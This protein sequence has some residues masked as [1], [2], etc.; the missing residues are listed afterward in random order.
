MRKGTSRV[1]DTR[2]AGQCV[3][4]GELSDES[5]VAHAG[6]VINNNASGGPESFLIQGFP[7]YGVW[8][9]VYGQRLIVKGLGF[10]ARDSARVAQ[11]LHVRH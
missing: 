7:V 8:S 2:E 5:R 1:K 11:Q 6:L 10:K 3:S 9:R 4:P